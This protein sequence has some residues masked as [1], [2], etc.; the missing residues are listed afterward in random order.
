ME[1]LKQLIV[2]MLVLLGPVIFLV[3]QLIPG[4]ITREKVEIWKIELL[5]WVPLRKATLLICE[6]FCCFAFIKCLGGLIEDFKGGVG[7]YILLTVCIISFAVGI[8]KYFSRRYRCIIGCEYM[9]AKALKRSVE[10]ETFRRINDEIWESEHWLRLGVRFFPKNLIADM[11]FYVPQNRL[12]IGADVCMLYGETYFEGALISEKDNEE[13]HISKKVLE[14]LPARKIK[15]C[16]GSRIVLS[17][18]KISK[19]Q[20]KEYTKNHLVDEVLDSMELLESVL[21]CHIREK[22]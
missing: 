12:S 18:C 9:D 17:Q 1:F 3:V 21:E 10:S 6:G 4:K 19:R 13:H 14:M 11:R 7:P 15:E 5:T 16:E 20:F 8:R 22:K 2:P